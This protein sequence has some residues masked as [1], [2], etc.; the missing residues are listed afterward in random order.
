MHQPFYKD[1]WTG[2]YKLPWTRLHAMKDY[3]GMVRILGEFPSLRQTFNLVPSMVAQIEEYA[4]GAAS[5]P[6]YDC[7]VTPAE[8]LSEPQNTFVRRY[9]FHAN[10]QR[11]ISRYPRYLELHA[12]RK[13]AFTVQEIRDVQ[14]LSQLAWYDEDLLQA[15][16][17]IQELVR[18]GRGFSRQDQEL[19]VRKQ[20]EALA[21]VLPV[22]R[23]FAARGRIEISTTPFYHPIL[24]LLCDSDIARVS[25]PAL[26]LPEPF[27]YPGDAKVQ[28]ER[29]R[30]YIAEKLGMRPVGLWPSEGAVSDEA[31]ELAAECGF[32]WAAS[33]NGVLGR[34]LDQTPGVEVTYQPYLWRDR[35][36]LVFRDHFLSDL[37]GFEYGRMEPAAAAEHF[38]ERIRQ[39]TNGR[40]MLAPIILDGE[41]AWE[42]YPGQGRPFLRELYRRIE[43]DPQLE[44]ATISEALA[45]FEARPLGRVFPGSWINANFDVWIGAEED[46]RAW[47][48]LLAA[49]RAYDEHAPRVSE[50]QRELAFE[51]LLIAEGSDWCWWY[52]P[53]HHSEERAEFDALYRDHLS[54]VYRALDL[55]VPEALRRS[56]L[57]AQSGEAHTPPF[58]PLEVVLD[59]EVTSAFEWMGA[60]HYRPDT[61]SGTM[62]G[63]AHAAGEMYY[64]RRG[65][66]LFVRLDGALPGARFAVEFENGRAET[67]M[68]AGHIVEL[69][70]PLHGRR[71]RIVAEREGLGSATLPAQG[72]IELLD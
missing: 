34:T 21:A 41:N 50:A 49:R 43:D 25:N 31:L 3:A 58:N 32:T 47:E 29:A 62:H 51:E 54:N 15:D 56:L 4:A 57:T 17:E 64:G 72:W 71:F 68:A 10:H 6:Y 26:T 59:G 5:D 39:N 52:G 69:E 53:E 24:P 16:A 35:L 13:E 36:R 23:D 19:M 11:V 44:A 65:G 18:K 38:L 14:V 1:L 9:L 37:I 22:Y 46:N 67:R 40:D 70:A 33:D 8:E 42:W 60:G 12:R 20:R 45:R 27:R 55:P 30:T 28:L 7:A 63:G 61:R 48:L 2:Q 66:T